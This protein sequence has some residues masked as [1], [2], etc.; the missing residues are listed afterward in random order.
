MIDLENVVIF[1]GIDWGVWKVLGP[2]II[3]AGYN[4]KNIFKEKSIP[5]LQ[6]KNVFFP[7]SQLLRINS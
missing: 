6:K 2:S 4:I 1:F 5:V 3:W 7:K